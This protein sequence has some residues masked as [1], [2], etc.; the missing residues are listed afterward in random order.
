MEQAIQFAAAEAA[1]DETILQGLGI[2][3]TLLI[4]QAIAFLLTVFVLAKWVYPVFMRIIDDREASIAES[5]VAA[6]KAKKAAEDAEKH[7]ASELQKARAEAADIVATAKAEA[8]QMSERADK[9][10]KER[11][12][13]TVADA[14]N[15]IE[16]SVIAARKSLEAD[17]IQLVQQAASIATSSV[18]DDKL[19][20]ALVK[21]SIAG[22]R[23]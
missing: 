14:Q 11:A 13:R 3:F 18:A 16:K 20:T 5:A 8:L 12:E 23:K 10:A 9:K 7:V 1:G 2:D 19:D 6:D 21:K 17:T 4:I 22:A 15:E